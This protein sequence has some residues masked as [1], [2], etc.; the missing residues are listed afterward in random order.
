MRGRRRR[1]PESARL[2]AGERRLLEAL[3][4]LLLPSSEGSP[5]AREA[6]VARSIERILEASPSQRA[7][8]ARGLESL[9]SSS[10]KRKG[11][12]FL[13]LAKEEQLELLRRIDRRSRTGSGAPETEGLLGKASSLCREARFPVLQFFPVLVQDVRRVF[14]TSP[15]AWK[16]LGYDGPPMP[17]G[18]P[19]VT[20]PRG[21]T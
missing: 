11:R 5:G 4:D 10:R 1:G 9:E 18:Y 3:S 7:L 21:R 6:E 16:W 19:D 13:E 15:V 14:Y 2:T 12:G 8:Y 17:D 20:R